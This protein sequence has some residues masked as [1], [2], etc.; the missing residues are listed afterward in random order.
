[1]GGIVVGICAAEACQTL[2]ATRL[3][4]LA[5]TLASSADSTDE[6]CGTPR[7]RLSTSLRTLFQLFLFQLQPDRPLPSTPP[8][9]LQSLLEIPP[10]RCTSRSSLS[11]SFST[12]Q[13][14]CQLYPG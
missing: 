5:R 7:L 10:K 1:M 12:T 2:V 13:S 3:G 14:W 6:L 11:T 4:P 9:D 8:T